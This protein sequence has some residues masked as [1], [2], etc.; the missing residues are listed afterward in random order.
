MMARNDDK[1]RNA[2]GKSTLLCE[3]HRLC[4]RLGFIGMALSPFNGKDGSLE[5]LLV[6]VLFA[7]IL[8]ME[9][10]FRQFLY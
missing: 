10:V 4:R 9:V 7:D 5:E 2:T 8:T 3:N 6:R 1:E